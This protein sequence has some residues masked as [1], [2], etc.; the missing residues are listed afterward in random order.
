M[1]CSSVFPSDLIVGS[2]C[3]GICVSKLNLCILVFA[4]NVLPYCGCM[5]GFGHGRLV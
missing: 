1:F 4:V 3:T 2:F 5:G